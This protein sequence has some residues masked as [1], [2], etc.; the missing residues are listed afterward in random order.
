[1]TPAPAP[2]LAGVAIRSGARSALGSLWSISDLG[3]MLSY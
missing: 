1:M 2:G 3:S